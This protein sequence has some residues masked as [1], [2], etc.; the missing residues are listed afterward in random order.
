MSIYSRIFHKSEKSKVNCCLIIERCLENNG[1]FIS[2]LNDQ[3]ENL[4][5]VDGLYSQPQ[6]F[7]SFPVFTPLTMRICSYSQQ[8]DKSF[9]SLLESEFNH[10]ICGQWN[11]SKHVTEV[12][13]STSAM[14]LFL[15]LSSQP[16][17]QPAQSKP[18]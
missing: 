8:K 15:M 3:S 5:V 18:K 11:I 2:D 17:P 9:S 16:G 6:F 4:F 13:K 1:A 7:L 14:L 10:E 12:L